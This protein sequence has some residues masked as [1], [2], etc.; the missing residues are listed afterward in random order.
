MSLT[1]PGYKYEI[2]NSNEDAGYAVYSSEQDMALFALYTGAHLHFINLWATE[3]PER[4]VLCC[5]CE[6]QHTIE[7]SLAAAAIQKI[8]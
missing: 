8:L 5:C 2:A 3:P 6:R 4:T 7:L 1:P